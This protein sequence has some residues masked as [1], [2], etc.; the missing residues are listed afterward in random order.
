MGISGTVPCLA[1]AAVPPGGDRSQ[2]PVLC[3]PHSSKFSV[4]PAAS[5]P[6]SGLSVTCSVSSAQ[7]QDS[8][9]LPRGAWWGNGRGSP[10]SREEV[11]HGACS[12]SSRVSV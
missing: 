12:L 7:A 5:R 1:L 11:M 4:E 6:P 8:T 3:V 9:T 2:L 10:P